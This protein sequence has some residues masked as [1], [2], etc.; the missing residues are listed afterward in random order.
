MLNV[1][2]PANTT[3]TVYVPAGDIE[4]VTE[5]GQPAAKAET[6]SFLRMEDGKAVFAVG[7]GDYRFVSKLPD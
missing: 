4:S 7:S 6:V 3:A 5:S 2:I 1:T